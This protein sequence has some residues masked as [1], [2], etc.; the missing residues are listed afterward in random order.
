[1]EIIDDVLRAGLPI[2]GKSCEGGSSAC[3][4]ETFDAKGNGADAS[5]DANGGS[6]D[7]RETGK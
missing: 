4:M 5:D 6:G 7:K 2:T 3:E 1:M